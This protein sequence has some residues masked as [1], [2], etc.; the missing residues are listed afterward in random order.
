[1]SMPLLVPCPGC[2]RHVEATSTDCPFCKVALVGRGFGAPDASAAPPAM[3]PEATLYGLPP[4]PVERNFDGYY[5]A[6]A[7]GM[8]PGHPSVLVPRLLLLLVLVAGGVL[9]W[10]LLRR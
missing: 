2:R 6:P 10:Y 8:A 9:A 3:R 1:M 7:Y 5:P 4:V